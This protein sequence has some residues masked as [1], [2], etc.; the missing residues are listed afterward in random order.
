M[1]SY[2][3]AL[4]YAK[5]IYGS[6]VTLSPQVY[7]FEGN[8]KYGTSVELINNSHGRFLMTKIVSTFSISINVLIR[9]PKLSSL[10]VQSQALTEINDCDELLLPVKYLAVANLGS[11]SRMMSVFVYGYDVE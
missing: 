3:T 9:T 6:G 8:I 2:D 10:A 11:D 4:M 5:A 7:K 1:I